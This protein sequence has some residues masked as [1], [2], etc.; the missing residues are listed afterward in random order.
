[1][2]LFVVLELINLSGVMAIRV[3]KHLLS[4]KFEFFLYF[5]S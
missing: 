3:K 1:M 5:C 2:V 4:F